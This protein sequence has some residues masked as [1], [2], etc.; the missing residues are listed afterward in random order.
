MADS[1]TVLTE[2][3][4]L[5]FPRVPQRVHQHASVYGHAPRLVL[6][7]SK[8]EFLGR[9]SFVLTIPYRSYDPITI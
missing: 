9:V 4:L 2:D 8:S 5:V 7:R 1:Q 3:G 6:C